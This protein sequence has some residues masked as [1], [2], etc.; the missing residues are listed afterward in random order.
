MRVEPKSTRSLPNTVKSQQNKEWGKVALIATVVTYLVLV[1]FLPTL[2]VFIGAFSRGISP[3]FANLTSPDFIQ[4]LRLTALA[5]A[6]AVPL[7]IVFGLCAAWVI[8][9]RRFR[10]RTLLLSII[11]LP[12]SI[13]PIVAGLM[14]VS[15]Y[16]RNGLLGPLL[17]SLD[18]KIIF[19]FPGIA[20]ATMM[21][22]MPFVAREVI[23][24]LEEVGTQ[25]E[26]AA[27]TL[28]A[29]EWQT[30]WRVTL[31]SIRW[32]LFYG[33]I[34]TTA[35]AMGEYGAIAVVSSNLIG[36]SQTLTLYVEEAYRN[37]DSQSAFAASV[38]LAGLAGATLVI[39]E[40]FER[41]IRI[42]DERD[43]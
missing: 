25:E 43:S 17:Q 1:L 39:K 27:K 38:V 5:V 32:G 40:L 19:S 28:G 14:L 10:G 8:A 6:V 24:I 18:I 42:K 2:Y 13:S 12:F 22:G 15:L 30:F 7:N 21:G 23:P 4:A 16:G 26:E 36:R 29:G 34:L 20:L 9:R 3:F 35:R 11:D 33:I 37:Y 31:P 41:R